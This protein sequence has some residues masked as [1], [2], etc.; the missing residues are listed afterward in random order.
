MKVVITPAAQEQIEHQLEHGIGRHGPATAR[1]TFARVERFLAIVL[2]DHPR[3]GRPLAVDQ[4]IESYI[5]KTPFVVIY[6]I[7]TAA[8]IVR[9]LALFHHAQYPTSFTPED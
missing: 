5:P 8:Q 1:K 4:L 9:V 7:E 6:R 3:L 2:A